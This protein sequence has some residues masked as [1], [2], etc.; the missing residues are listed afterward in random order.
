MNA[1]TGQARFAGNWGST[2]ANNDIAA[3]FGIN[4]TGM[5]NAWFFQARGGVRPIDKLDIMASVSYAIADRTTWALS[6]APY[7][8]PDFVS[9]VY[10]TEIDLLQHIKSRTI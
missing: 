4:D 6:S 10:G 3:A 8:M 9:N 2:T 7:Y 1:L 5:Y